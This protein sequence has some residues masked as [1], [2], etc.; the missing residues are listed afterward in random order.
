[1]LQLPSPILLPEAAA[2]EW[3]ER[4]VSEELTA[5]SGRFPEFFWLVFI[6]TLSTRYFLL[7]YIRGSGGQK[8]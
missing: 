4:D 5:Y 7:C 2:S 1:M 8:G 6:I 3:E